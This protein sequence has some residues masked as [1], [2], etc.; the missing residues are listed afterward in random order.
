MEK[1]NS[2]ISPTLRKY[3]EA[4]DKDIESLLKWEKKFKRFYNEKNINELTL[5]IFNMR[6]IQGKMITN[7][8]FSINNVN[9]FVKQL[10]GEDINLDM[11]YYNISLFEN[12]IDISKNIIK[13]CEDSLHK[14]LKNTNPESIHNKGVQNMTRDE[15][16]ELEFNNNS[17]ASPES[18]NV[19][20]AQTDNT[21][22]GVIDDMKDFKPTV[23]LFY[24]SW[25]GGSRKFLPTW[26]SV[27]KLNY[28][29]GLKFVTCECGDK[30]E[31]N[32]Q[33][34]NK[35]NIEF[36]PSIKLFNVVN[37]KKVISTCD[38]MKVQSKNHILQWIKNETSLLPI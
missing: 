10:N 13:E 20:Q 4:S 26:D 12:Y 35:Y 24:A 27:K 25:C 30:T 34:L 33:L 32:R 1:T 15:F 36:Y 31:S 5:C 3:K 21:F 6:I 2:K 11:N 18:S 28:N 14:I 17:T 23:V 7:F 29:G 9:D 22:E 38:L 37:S 16:Q 19:N 8:H